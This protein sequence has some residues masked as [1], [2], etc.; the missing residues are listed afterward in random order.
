MRNNVS[1]FFALFTLLWLVAV[2]C[3]ACSTAWTSEATNIIDLL[4]PAI[5]SA[6]SILSAFGVGVPLPT[7]NAVNSWGA[8]ANEALQTVKSLIDQYN[9]AEAN[10]KPGL[11]SEIQSALSTIV[12]NA[13]Q[14][15]SEV[16]INDTKTQAQVVAIFDTVL[17]ELQSLINLVP[18]LKGEVTKHDEL[19]ALV[20][21][22]KT[23]KEFKNEFN[24][25]VGAF[26]K[27]YEI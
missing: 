15:L 13:G 27:Q 21:Q 26:G 19:K 9:Q 25:K 14:V 24:E 10:A 18:A 17:A 3:T 6:L 11:L 23:P 16:H 5:T 4:V 8:Q 12:A 1:R 22:V 20:A 2:F 7:V